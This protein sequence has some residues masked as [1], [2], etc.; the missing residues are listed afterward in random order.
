MDAIRAASE[1]AMSALLAQSMR[2]RIVAENIA[3]AESTGKTPGAEPYRRKTISFASVV[4]QADGVER[5]AVAKVGRD[6]APFRLEEIP[7]H[8]AA[9]SAG[10]VKL[11]NINMIYEMADMRQASRS[12]E[13]N[14]QVVKQG[15]EMMSSLVD[16]LRSTG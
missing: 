6:N 1:T 12:Y 3:N 4:G 5:L 2:M 15:G 7:G 13:A 10:L 16:L 9:D 14:L 8:P 11:P